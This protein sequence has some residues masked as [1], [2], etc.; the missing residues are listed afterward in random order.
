[1]A[2]V[3]C[4]VITIFLPLIPLD[5]QLNY[6]TLHSYPAFL[7][8]TRIRRNCAL[9]K[10]NSRPS[11]KD[12]PY[13]YWGAHW[14]DNRAGQQNLT[15]VGSLKEVNLIAKV[16]NLTNSLISTQSQNRNH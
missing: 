12:N 15:E 10:Y 3:F 16:G 14:G 7:L 13:S 6:A 4:L 9:A 5:Y 11:E 8:Y 2:P 1:M